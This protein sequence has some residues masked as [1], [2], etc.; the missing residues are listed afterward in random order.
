MTGLLITLDLGQDA[1]SA[2]AVAEVLSDW[3]F[4]AAMVALET[5]TLVCVC[6]WVWRTWR[7]WRERRQ[8]ARRKDRNP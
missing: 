2:L 3:R 6:R 8:A 4:L 1:G 5:A 7:A